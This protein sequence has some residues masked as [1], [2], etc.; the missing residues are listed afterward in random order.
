MNLKGIGFE[1][2]DWISGQGLVAGWCEHGT[3]NFGKFLDHLRQY[4]NFF[5]DSGPFSKLLDHE[6]KSQ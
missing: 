4:Y 1:G 2:V 5:K 3:G 6:S